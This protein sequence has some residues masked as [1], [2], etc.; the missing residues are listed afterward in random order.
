MQYLKI[1]K[2]KKI[3]RKDRY[4]LTVNAT[5]NFFANS[6][7]IHNTSGISSKVLCKKKLNFVERALK[8]LGVNIVDK[9]YDYLYSS[10]KVIKNEELNP[11]AQHY[12]NEDIWGL[13]HKELEEYLEDGLTLYY[14]VVGNL[15]S[16]GAIQKDYDYGYSNGFGIYIYRITYTNPSGKVFEFSSKQVQDWCNIRMLNA[17]PELFYGYAK[18]INPEIFEKYKDDEWRGYF[19]DTIKEIYNDKNCYMCTKKVPEEGVVI[20]I[21]GNELEAF[22]QKSFKFYT[23]ETSLLDKNYQ[24]IESEN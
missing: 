4:D 15:P 21:E 11:N 2:I 6:I 14:E 10:R 13:A 18:N 3:H 20:R 9:E 5:K 22:K 16:G 19:L 17:V 8:F 12:Y 24:D 1:K 23:M 7:L